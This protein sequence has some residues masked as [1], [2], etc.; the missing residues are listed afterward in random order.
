MI[1]LMLNHAMHLIAI[2]YLHICMVSKKSTTILKE[3]IK[4][5]TKIQKNI[6]NVY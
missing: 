3:L 4:Q 2:L 1:N 5:V 6:K